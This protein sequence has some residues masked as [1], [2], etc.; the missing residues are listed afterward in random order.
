MAK[1]IQNIFLPFGLKG[2]IVLLLL[3]LAPIATIF[4]QENEKLQLLI[5]DAEAAKLSFIESNPDMEDLFANTY[6]Y[7]IFPNLGKGAFILGVSAGSG[8]VW[9]NEELIGEAKLREVSVGLQLGG[10][11]FQLVI[12]YDNDEAFSRLKANKIEFRAQAAALA[13][14]KG[15][16]TKLEMAEGIQVFAK[17]KKGIMGEVAIGG[18][19]FRFKRFDKPIPAKEPKKKISVDDYFDY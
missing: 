13:D 8:L 12:F 4:A 15:T 3:V 18:Q 11:A 19:K 5:A 2:T 9:Q 17:P 10:Q 14:S 16:S 7:A 6:G 1:S